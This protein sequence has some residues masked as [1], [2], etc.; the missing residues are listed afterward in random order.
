MADTRDLLG[1][2]RPQGDTRAA[3]GIHWM[4]VELALPGA[5]GRISGGFSPAPSCKSRVDWTFSCKSLNVNCISHNLI[6][7][8]FPRRHY[9]Y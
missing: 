2:S 4:S 1:N 8:P 6:V 5:V 9:F 7:A 3:D